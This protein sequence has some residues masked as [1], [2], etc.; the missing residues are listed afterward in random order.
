MQ[1]L[2]LYQGLME[3]SSMDL[4]VGVTCLS[5]NS[6]NNLLAGCTDGTV[7]ILD[8]RLRSQ[9]AR[10]QQSVQ[11]VSTNVRKI[12]VNSNQHLVA[13]S[14]GRGEVVT[15]DTRMTGR[16]CQRIQANMAKPTFLNWL[17]GEQVETLVIGGSNG[18]QILQPL[19]DPGYVQYLTPSLT[20]GENITCVDVSGSGTYIA[21]GTD[22]GNVAVFEVSGG[23]H[24][25]YTFNIH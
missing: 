3:T 18:I 14:G 15:F 23:K 11:A 20:H 16:A 17:P 5:C 25:I 9:R 19:G 13:V 22:V 6:G 7:K 12:K 2:D 4:N 1:M 8:G 10:Y 24:I 21:A